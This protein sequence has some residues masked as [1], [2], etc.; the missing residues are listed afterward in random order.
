[1]GPDKA[2]LT[3]SSDGLPRR[4]RAFVS[5]RSAI[6]RS[7]FPDVK[8]HFLLNAY[9]TAIVFLWVI[10]TDNEYLKRL[11]YDSASIFNDLDVPHEIESR[12]TISYRQGSP[13]YR[14]VELY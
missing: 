11:K 3:S 9:V 6:G 1:M 5:A 7:K 2:R 12:T 10:L 4:A 8:L 14:M 13:P